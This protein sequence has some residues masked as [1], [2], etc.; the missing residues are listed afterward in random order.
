MYVTPFP[1]RYG[2]IPPICFAPAPLN[3]G[4]SH[5]PGVHDDRSTDRGWRELCERPSSAPRQE[6]RRQHRCEASHADHSNRRTR[7]IAPEFVSRAEWLAVRKEFLV[8]EKELTRLRDRLN[9]ER[10]NLPWV[11][12][13]KARR[14]QNLSAVP[15]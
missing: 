4:G 10:R 13:R 9:A 11:T 14:E 5:V 7:W 8:K 12:L 3:G 1:S 2:A 6:S 15:Q